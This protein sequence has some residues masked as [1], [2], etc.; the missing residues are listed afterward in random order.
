[1]K[2]LS[3]MLAVTVVLLSIA[4]PS[5]SSAQYH[6]ERLDKFLNEHQNVKAYLVRNPNLIYD[7]SFREQ[8]PEL[9]EF[10]QNNPQI[11]GKLA[12]NGRWGAYGPDHQWHEA[13][14]WREHDPSWVSK[15]HPEWAHNRQPPPTLP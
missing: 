1:M 8:H 2:H 11:W 9:Q 5:I 15:N 4:M 13:D 10:M 6:E 14:W 7:K 3:A 12:N